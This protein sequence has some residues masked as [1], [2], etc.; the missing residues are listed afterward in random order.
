MQTTSNINS[1]REIPEDLA[2]EHGKH[3]ANS[4]A[5]VNLT[6]QDNSFQISAHLNNEKLFN[7][8]IAVSDINILTLRAMILLKLKPL[9]LD[10]MPVNNLEVRIGQ[11]LMQEKYSGFKPYLLQI[12]ST[13]NN[14]N[15][16]LQDIDDQQID[17]GHHNN[18]LIYNLDGHFYL[19]N[20][21]KEIKE[22]NRAFY[23]TFTTG[24]NSTK[25]QLDS[26]PQVMTP[27]E[28]FNFIK[29]NEIGRI[30]SINLYY[31]EAIFD[32]HCVYLL[33]LLARLGVEYNTVDW[34]IY[35]INKM[36]GVNKLC[37]HASQFKRYD[38]FPSIQKSW[39]EKFN[40]ANTAYHPGQA[41]RE[42]RQSLQPLNDNYQILCAANSRLANFRE[43]MQ[44]EKVLAAFDFCE[45]DNLFHDFQ[46]WFH[47]ISLFLIRD[48]EAPPLEKFKLRAQLIKVH[49]DG[50]SLLKYEAL[51][52]ISSERPVNLYGDEEWQFIFPQY[53]QGKYL[54]KEEVV[55][56][57]RSGDYLH[58]QLNNIFSYPEAHS[59]ISEALSL[60]RP[61]LGFPAVVKTPALEGF[62]GLEYNN[63]AQLN[64]RLDNI[65]SVIEGDKFRSSLRAH[66]KNMAVC[67]K[68]F[69]EN[70]SE[71]YIEERDTY[72]NICEQHQNQF[73][74]DA[75]SYIT[76]KRDRLLDYLRFLQGI[77]NYD[78]N[79]ARYREKPYINTIVE[80]RTRTNA[81]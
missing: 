64:H 44:L 71:G 53:Y 70:L 56:K 7:H 21:Y 61:Y 17:F 11:E 80:Y 13:L 2:F 77:H 42:E 57:I 4:H 12:A 76:D 69:C 31:L 72:N 6:L 49:F 41:L 28:L 79:Q 62:E 47:A 73:A 33:A 43:P 59:V 37:F 35:A 52:G 14:T 9:F 68:E 15:K 50:I 63:I 1:P 32:Y 66:S 36:L 60:H 58:L 54:P 75:Q 29:E 16:L 24:W 26:P 5:I 55:A 48:V 46:F 20:V 65:N 22:K 25:R 30:V 38:I 34:D 40:L 8:E 3:R 74:L 67:W 51:N 10:L 23:Q 19:E 78:A 45:E 18:T 27:S 39:N 81:Q